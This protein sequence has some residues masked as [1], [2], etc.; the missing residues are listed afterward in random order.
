M[1]VEEVNL[2]FDKQIK[3]ELYTK[4]KLEKC[5][6]YWSKKLFNLSVTLNIE[7]WKAIRTEDFWQEK[8]FAE[9]EIDSMKISIQRIENYLN[10]K[11]Q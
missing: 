9:N 10:Y 8:R 6:S 5:P 7:D 11:N 3:Y 2:K 4:W 1:T